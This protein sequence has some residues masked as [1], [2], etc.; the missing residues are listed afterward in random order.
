MNYKKPILNVV[1]FSTDDA[2]S[3]SSEDVFGVNSIP[4]AS[5]E[6]SKTKT[7]FD[8]NPF[9]I[10]I[11]TEVAMAISVLLLTKSKIITIIYL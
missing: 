10:W 7:M 5:Y 11:F 9:F 4:N 6:D 1:K 8:Y 2:I 3:T